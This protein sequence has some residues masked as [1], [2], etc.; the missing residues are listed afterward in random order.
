[1]IE[2]SIALTTNKTENGNRLWIKF[3][4]TN[5]D[6]NNVGVKYLSDSKIPSDDNGSESSISFGDNSNSTTSDNINSA[7]SD[8]SVSTESQDEMGV[9][10]SNG[11]DTNEG[12]TVIKEQTQHIVQGGGLPTSAIIILVVL[13][14]IIL[15]VAV[16]W[17]IYFIKNKS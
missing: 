14:I 17:I 5:G 16:F 15:G 10:S 3:I 2:N 4:Y 13:G 9:N 8:N 11:N 7:V 1:M 12:G 6:K